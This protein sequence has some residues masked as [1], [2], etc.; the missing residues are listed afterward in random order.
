MLFD[1]KSQHILAFIHNGLY[2][3][4]SS[5]ISNNFWPG[6]TISSCYRNYVCACICL[7]LQAK[8]CLRTQLSNYTASTTGCCCGPW[9]MSFKASCEPRSP[10]NLFRPA[11]GG[12]CVQGVTVRCSG[13][14][15]GPA[16]GIAFTISSS[17]ALRQPPCQG[18]IWRLRSYLVSSARL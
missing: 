17:S 13:H 1:Q 15:D 6:A 9:L 18:L 2:I 5:T 11:L 12:R 16:S 7:T 8:V 10:V 3:L 14:G 4:W